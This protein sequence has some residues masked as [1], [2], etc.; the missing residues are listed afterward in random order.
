MAVVPVASI[1]LDDLELFKD[2]RAQMGSGLVM[3]IPVVVQNC[4]NLLLNDNYTLS[5]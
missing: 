2:Q 4:D 5:V 3:A 1:G